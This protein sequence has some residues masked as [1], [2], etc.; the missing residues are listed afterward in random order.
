MAAIVETAIVHRVL[1]FDAD[2]GFCQRW[3]D[4]ARRRGA[5]RAI[6][7]EP[8]Q[9]AVELR[10]RAGISEVDCG[11]AAFLVECGPSG[12]VLRTHRA[13]GA[14]NGVLARLPG[15]R[16]L[17]WRWLSALYRVP[18]LNLLEEWGYR[19]I[20]RN[21]HRLAGGSCRIDQSR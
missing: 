20:A 13:A 6:R 1:L 17:I 18:G 16:N 5:E 3:C 19:V 4:W 21:R 2:C 10:Q 9:P 12:D 8:C 14:I 11:H 15:A 7:F